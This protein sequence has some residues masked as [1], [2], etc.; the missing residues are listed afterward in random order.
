M[1]GNVT[2]ISK[3]HQIATQFMDRE[4]KDYKST[5]DKEMSIF[6]V[7][8]QGVKSKECKQ[9]PPLWRGEFGNELRVITPWA[10]HVKQKCGGISTKGVKGTKYLY[11]FSNKHII[12]KKKREYHDLPKGNPLKHHW[13]HFNDTE[14]PEG[15]AWRPP[16]YSHF[17]HR[18]EFFKFIDKE[19]V[20]VLNKYTIE[21]H[22]EPRN[23][24][25]VQTLTKMFDY[26]TPKYTVLYKRDTPK[27]LEDSQENFDLCE[28]DF[29]RKKYGDKILFFEDFSNKLDNIEDYNLLS[30]GLFS[31]SNKFLT[32]QGGTA[33]T[34]SYF[35]GTNII[36]I[37]KGVELKYKDY[38][39]FHRFS[40]ATIIYEKK[41]S[42]FLREMK[43]NM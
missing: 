40:N 2:N 14:F 26:L 27:A 20:V 18:P 34:G 3:S 37:K 1:G 7:E 6:Q 39:Y 9:R 12:S 21:W 43:Y 13:V 15:A 10:Y 8:Y 32:V 23:Y 28:K 11:Y 42:S 5:I 41:D 29:L 19:L 24:F 38:T 36:L 17:F 31:M 4:F 22:K 35:G 30:F 25:S 16:P 33:V